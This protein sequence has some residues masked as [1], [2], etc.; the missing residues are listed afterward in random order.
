MPIGQRPPRLTEPV[1]LTEVIGEFA[2]ASNHTLLATDRRG[3]RWVYKPQQGMSP[4]SDFSAASLPTREILAYQVAAAMGLTIVPET[5]PAVGPLGPG[6]AQLF[7]EADFDFD[8]R[9]L[10]SPDLDPVLWPV[11]VLDLVCNNADR[12]IGHL[13]SERANG[14]L[15]AIDNG[16]TFHPEPK[17]R[18]VLWGFAGRSLPSAMTSALESLTASLDHYLADEVANLLGTNETVSLRDRVSALAANPLHP[19]PPT[20]RPALPWPIW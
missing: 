8:P 15:W 18:T 12:K 17:L 13:L 2:S 7:I 16:L 11:A 20:D 10:L 19:H 1:R 4:L 14:Q 3:V 9:P 5:S 6:S